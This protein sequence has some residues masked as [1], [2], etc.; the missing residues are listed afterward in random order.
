MSALSSRGLNSKLKGDSFII[1][2]TH[3]ENFVIS[4]E[5]FDSH[6]NVLPGCV[7]A[8]FQQL[9]GNHAEKLGVGFEAMLERKLLWVVTQI[10]YQ[11][12]GKIKPDMQLFGNTW[13]LSPSRI[14]YE[15]EYLLCDADGNALI[16]GVSHWA[17]IDTE[18]RQLTVASNVYPEMEHLTDKVFDERMRRLR[19]FEATSE[20][21]KICPDQSTIDGNGHVN[22]TQYA[23]FVV[24]A[25]QEL[26][27]EIDTFQMDYINEVMCNQPLCLYHT[28]SENSTLVK[29][30]DEDGKRMF[31]CAITFK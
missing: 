23:D 2:N 24:A 5:S 21:F 6:G 22:N 12:C 17:L 28:A 26:D 19:D 3:S 18:Q 9:A 8:M 25:L 10:K 15:R 4:H 30:L 1:M 7:L 13:P 31:A 20:A 27:G 29:G 14:G 11:V 16:K